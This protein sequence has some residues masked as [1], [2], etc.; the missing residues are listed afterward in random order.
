[1]GFVAFYLLVG[2]G[3]AIGCYRAYRERYDESPN[4]LFL[5]GTVVFWPFLIIDAAL[6][7]R[8]DK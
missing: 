6:K 5:A 7:D 3:V 2:L 1:M 4:W 8:N